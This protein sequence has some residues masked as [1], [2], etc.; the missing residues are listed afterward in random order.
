MKSRL[1]KV[2]ILAASLLLQLGTTIRAHAV[3]GDVDL[4]FDP[5]SGVN[6]PV[7]AVAVQPGGKVLIGGP[8][9]FINGTNRYGSARLNPD[10]SVDGTFIPGSFNPDLSFVIQT[11]D[12]RGGPDFECSQSWV[13]SSVLVQ[14]DGKVLVGGYTAT[15]DVDL[16]DN[17]PFETYRSFLARVHADGSRDTNFAPVIGDQSDV[18]LGVSALAL[19]PDGKVLVGGLQVWFTRRNADGSVD[20]GFNPNITGRDS[21][22]SIALQAD[23]KVLIGG[24][25]NSMHGTN[26][27]YG[28]AR[29]KADGTLDSSF[30]PS[31]GRFGVS[32]VASQPDGKVLIGGSFTSFSGTPRNRIARLNTDGSLDLGFNPG[33]GPDGA[34]RSLALQPDGNILIGGEFTTVNGV[35]RPRI[36][37]LYG[38]SITP[39]LNLIRSGGNLVLTWPVTALNFQ[40]QETTNVALPN[41]WSPVAQSRMTNGAQISVTV[42]TSAAQ[43]FFRLQ[44]P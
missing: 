11:G 36:A 28:V 2:L 43:M 15:V 8:L 10:G 38:D 44:S 12:C 33:T 19:Q 34:I 4:S 39:A 30:N 7:N 3:A 24:D 5:G 6:G 20:N 16:S 27:S 35:V 37:R 22:V 41:A 29:L 26:V 13:I 21:V 42:P 14:T 40:L 17:H 23:G 9:T 25:F 18:P 31:A 32:S 1:V